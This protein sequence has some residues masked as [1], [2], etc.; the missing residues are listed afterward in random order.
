CQA[1]NVTW[2]NA[3][4]TGCDLSES[5]LTQNVWMGSRLDHISFQRSDL[6]ESDFQ[7]AT[8]V[9][10]DF[11]RAHTLNTLFEDWQP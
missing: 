6:F 10:C 8:F 3:R 11:S 1:A 9:E 7:H 2:L 5:L 4:L